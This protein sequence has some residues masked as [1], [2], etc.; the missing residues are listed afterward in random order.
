MPVRMRPF[1]LWGEGCGSAL[2]S[3]AVAAAELLQ[4]LRAEECAS[5]K[6]TVSDRGSFSDVFFRFDLCCVPAKFCRDKQNEV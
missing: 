1:E 5:T 3:H 4:V 2:S 6:L